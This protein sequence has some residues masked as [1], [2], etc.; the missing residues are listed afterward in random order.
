MT[1]ISQRYDFS[2]KRDHFSALLAALL[3]FGL[4]LLLQ[5][6]GNIWF[7]HEAPEILTR[8]EQASEKIDPNEASAASLQRLPDIGPARARKIIEF[9]RSHGGH[10]FDNLEDLTEVPG[11]GPIRAKKMAPY[12]TFENK[13]N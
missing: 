10:P 9:R 3:V 12:L 5:A 7:A 6:R 2:W 11:I 8:F 4:I 1:P 13:E